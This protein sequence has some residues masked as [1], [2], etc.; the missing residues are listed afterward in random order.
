MATRK[1][2]AS[3]DDSLINRRSPSDLAKQSEFLARTK[4]NITPTSTSDARVLDKVF[5]EASKE[6]NLEKRIDDFANRL[7]STKVDELQAK[8]QDAQT[9]NE[10]LTNVI[11][12]LQVK[13]SIN[14]GYR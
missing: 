2:S 3:H 11:Q 14:S 10:Y 13:R 7:E 1:T 5:A 12:E 6:K 9:K 8:L 4:T